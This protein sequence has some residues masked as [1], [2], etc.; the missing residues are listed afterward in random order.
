M[1]HAEYNIKVLEIFKE[2]DIPQELRGTLSYM[3]Y[4]RGH[5][6]GESEVCNILSEMCYNLKEP[7]KTLSNRIKIEAL[8]S[9]GYK[10]AK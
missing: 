4:E 5:S 6:A 8:Q 1:D 9:V 7:L 3:A 2:N 10:L